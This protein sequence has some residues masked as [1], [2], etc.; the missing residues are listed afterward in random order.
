MATNKNALIRY[1]TIDTCLRNRS[2]KWNLND[3]ID[4]CSDALYEYEGKDS[5]VSKRTIQL[6]LQMMRSDKLGYSAPIVCYERKFYTYSDP[7]YSITNLP[8]SQLD[9]E[10]LRE[11]MMVLS[12]FKDF[13]LFDELN[14]VIQKLE[15]RVFRST[16]QQQSIIYMDR[17]DQLKGLRYLETIYQSILK[18]IVLIITYKSFKSRSANNIKFHAFILREFN[19]RWFVVGR[20][21]KGDKLLTL[22]LDRIEAVD[23]DLHTPYIDQDFD[24]K[25]YYK[26]TI[27]VTVL[28]D[29]SL[30]NISF[31]ADRHNAPYIFT[32]PIHHSQKVLEEHDDHS[33]TFSIRVH[34]NYELERLLLGFGEGVRVISPDRLSRRIMAKHRKALANYQ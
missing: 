30:L 2:R 13:S 20:K 14:G 19:N 5:M 7:T 29:S 22:A 8:V 28:N 21:E 33:M 32:K 24:A 1:K 10:V 3:L 34:H 15:D 11:S 4:S 6:D 16:D 26:N 17:N 18:K 12:H 9:L 27:G 31:W 23:I 25:D